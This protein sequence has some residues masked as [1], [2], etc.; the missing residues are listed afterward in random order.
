M[1]VKNRCEIVCMP[2]GWRVA[3][4]APFEPAWEELAQRAAALGT[5]ILAATGNDSERNRRPTS[6]VRG[7]ANCPSVV[8]VGAVDRQMQVAEF[9]NAGG[10]DAS[11]VVDFVAPGV[12]I[13]SAHVVP[14]F[15]QLMSGTSQAVAMAAGI[16]ALHA[17][18]TGRRGL[19]LRE[20]LR[21]SARP[22][23]LSAM[24]AGN[25]LV[26]APT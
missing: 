5:L 7:P 17:E 15:Y 1:A 16:A 24:D 3:R 8:A 9:S 26:Q 4:G 23:A 25:G 21:R 11:E 20:E 19:A 12:D 6:P 18:K 14:P 2:I 22:L 10:A 13:F